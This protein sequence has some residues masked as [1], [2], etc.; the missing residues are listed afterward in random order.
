MWEA[1]GGRKEGRVKKKEK[2]KNGR[3]KSKILEQK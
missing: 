3:G 2:K 1:L